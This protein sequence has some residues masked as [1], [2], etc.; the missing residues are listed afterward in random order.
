MRIGWMLAPLLASTMLAGPAMAQQPSVEELIRR[1]DK[2][3]SRVDELETERRIVPGHA[4]AASRPSQAAKSR[5]VAAAP[6]AVQPPVG[7]AAATPTGAPQPP[8]PADLAATPSWVAQLQP[9]EPM[10]TFDEALRSN[11]PGLSFRLPATETEVRFYGFVKLVGWKDFDARNQTDAPA[12]QSIPLIGSNAYLQGGDFSMTAQ[13]SRFG[14]DTRTLTTLG[15]LETRLEGDFGGNGNTFRLRQAF[16][17]LGDDSFRVLIGQANSLWNEG[18]IETLIDATNLNQSFVRQAQLRLTGRLAPGLTGMVSLEAPDTD[19]TSNAGVF[20]PSSNLQGGASPAF[21]NAPDLLGRL[22]YRYNG[23]DIGLRSLLR[24]LSVH[25]SGTAA[26]LPGKNKDAL[27]WGLALNTRVPMRL[28]WEGLGPDELLGMVFYGEGI[29]RYMGGNSFGQGALS[30]IGLPGTAT[31]FSLNPVPTWGVLGGYRRI[32]TTQL[33]SNVSYAYTRQ[34]FPSYGLQFAPGSAAATSLNR[35]MQQIF[36][37]LIWSPFAAI[38]NGTLNTGR[39]DAGIEYVYSRRDLYG[40]AAAAGAT[41]YGQ[42]IA[43]RLLGAV[44]VRF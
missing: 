29:G 19:Y 11:L 37:N 20:T 31:G 8:L 18:V 15:T 9:P 16:A 25:S 12:P 36:V 33:R 41:G 1:I 39:I 14:I 24:D 21:N 3:Q 38:Q 5:S 26:A 22:N 28:L 7:A 10:G 23:I 13:R 17:E 6:P 2:L 40:G 27:G 30:N 35:E 34:D 42:G 32:W 44:I 43:N 4:A